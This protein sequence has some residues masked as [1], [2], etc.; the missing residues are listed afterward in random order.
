[1]KSRVRL[2]QI[3][4]KAKVVTNQRSD[5]GLSAGLVAYGDSDE[6][7]SS[8]SE[9]N[10]APQ[11]SNI[12]VV[13]PV[14]TPPTSHSSADQTSIDDAIKQARRARAKQWSERRK[15]QQGADA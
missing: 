3:A 7:S 8:D 1:M 6:G 5:S 15:L 11:S 10:D 14:A 4:E 2:D 12:E 13:K 9:D